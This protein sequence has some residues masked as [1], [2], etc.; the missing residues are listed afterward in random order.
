MWSVSEI[1]KPVCNADQQVKGNVIL[2]LLCVCLKIANYE[3]SLVSMSFEEQS[4]NGRPYIATTLRYGSVLTRSN[5]FTANQDAISAQ[6][7][8]A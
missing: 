3:F 7:T 8:D 6:V 4:L 5:L 2:Y 1:Q